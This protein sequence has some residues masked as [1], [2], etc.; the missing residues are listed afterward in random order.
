MKIETVG[1]IGA[2]AIGGYFIWGLSEILGDNLWVI[3]DGKR[4]EKLQREGLCIND[5]NYCLNVKT[6]EEAYNVNLLIV[7]TKYGALKAA[8]P[9]IKSVTG[10]NTIVLSLLNGVDSEDI[11]AETVGYEP[12]LY[13]LMKIASRREGHNIYF[14][15]PSTVGLLFGEKDTDE[16]TERIQAVVDLLTPTKLHFRVCKD[17]KREIWFK[18]G[19]NIG[20]NLLQSIF[21]CGAGAYI[22][23]EYMSYLRIK[24]REE[25]IEVAKAK[26]IDISEVNSLNGRES[27]NAYNTRY[28][29]LQD[30]DAGR[31]TEIDMFS[32]AMVRMGKELGIATP[33]NDFVY[34]AI[35]I[36]EE[37]NDGRFDY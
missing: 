24:L 21:N 37:K 9:I 12:L 23:S 19:V 33:Y 26:G 4:K 36:I 20:I 14:D 3:A 18:Y 28:S 7:S 25:V 13:G 11:I 30:L 16:V 8:L 34:N 17:I 22:D 32:G 10:P 35:K 6:P 2:G 31:H 27:I 29:T 15:G 5:K 1:I